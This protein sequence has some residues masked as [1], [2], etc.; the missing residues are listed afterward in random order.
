MQVAGHARVESSTILLLSRPI[1]IASSSIRDPG[2]NQRSSSRQQPLSMVPDAKTSPGK[3]VSSR[4]AFS[5][6]WPQENFIP[7]VWP[8]AHSS[9]STRRTISMSAAIDFVDGNDAGAQ[10]VTLIEILALARAGSD[11]APRRPGCLAR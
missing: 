6:I 11:A 1:P 8:R 3:I 7:L 2:L 4:E 10:H 5:M 9:P